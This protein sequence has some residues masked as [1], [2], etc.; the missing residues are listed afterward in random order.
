MN[1][2][3]IILGA[4]ILYGLIKGFINGL[5]IEVASLA[6]LIAGVFGAIHF[7]Y[8]AG[9][10]LSQRLDWNE[11]YINLAAFAITFIAILLGVSLIGK[12]LTKLADIA[13]L[14]LINK[15]MGSVFGALKFV[16]ILGGLLIF[17]SKMTMRIPVLNSEHTAS[18]ILY[19]PVKD[20]GNL[21]FQ[22][23]LK[24]DSELDD[25]SEETQVH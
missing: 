9:I 2:I 8:I 19:H 11:E 10:Y 7:S 21:V 24:K 14:G 13:A 18:S 12:L 22:F 15:L 25:I 6:A 1:F 16:V 4:L 3:D 20:L 5:F 23:I 17:T